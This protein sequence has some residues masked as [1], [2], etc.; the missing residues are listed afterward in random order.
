STLRLITESRG[1]PKSAIVISTASTQQGQYPSSST[2]LPPSS[3][4]L[5][6]ISLRF[7]KTA[8][9]LFRR[10][11]IGGTLSVG[12]LVLGLGGLDPVCDHS[13][14]RH[15]CGALSLN[16]RSPPGTMPA[17]PI[18]LSATSLRTSVR[19]GSSQ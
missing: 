11:V 1:L 17:K 3:I 8:L 5:S 9:L 14:A 4:S 6:A 15:V 2:S 7:S 16:R 10:F 19:L 12:G 13:A 18:T